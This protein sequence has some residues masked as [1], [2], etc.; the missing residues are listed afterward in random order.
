[1]TNLVTIITPTFNRAKY[2]VY[3]HESL[4]K[5][6]NQNFSWV[7]VDDG[8]TDN[9]ENLVEQL[10]NKGSINITYL[11]QVNGGK[12]RAL[13]RGLKEIKS[14][15]TIVVDSDDTLIE[16]A[17]NEIYLAW[18]SI[19]DQKLSGISFLKGYKN[20]SLIGAKFPQDYFVSTFSEVR[21]NMNVRGDKAEVWVTKLLQE[22]PFPEFENEKFFSE[23]YVWIK[24]SRILPMLFV[25]KIIY[26]VEYLEDGL[27][28]SGRKLRMSCPLGGAENARILLDK[29][30]VLKVR[31][32]NALLYHNYNIQAGNSFSFMISQSKNKLLIVTT[33]P[34]GLLL[35]FYWKIRYS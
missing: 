1:M 2:L 31:I 13:N 35:Y 20:S 12:H 11:K 17:I 34:F 30:F 27:S 33:I 18:E 15:L 22:N 19:G 29:E 8:S 6:T 21:I 14:E 32:K 23:N 25:N 28:S 26:L 5:Q 4:E 7:I 16:N 9:T 24:I 3:L 10:I